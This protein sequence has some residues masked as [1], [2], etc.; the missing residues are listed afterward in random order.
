MSGRFRKYLHVNAS[1]AAAW[2][3]AGP[4]LAGICIFIL[5]PFLLAVFLSFTNLALGSPLPLEFVG[6][7]QYRVIF[8]DTGFSRALLNNLLFLTGI[9]PTQT[10][11]AL[12][13]AL[14]LNQRLKGIAIYR[15]LFFMPV[16]FPMS[17]IAVIWTLIYAPGPDGLMNTF[18]G[19][20]T[21]GAWEPRD[22]INHP[23]LALPAIMLLSVWQG[24]GF[25][26]VVLL[27]GLQ[28]I[29]ENLYEAAAIDGAGRWSRFVHVTL[30]GL[31]NPL[32][33]VI[34]ITSILSFRVFDQVRIM[35]RGGPRNA[36]TTVVFEAVRVG[37]DRGQVAMGA[38]MSVIF[39]LIV[40]LITVI[41]RRLL[42]QEG[43][44]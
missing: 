36:T 25:Q 31:R 41:Q 21:F 7:R 10:L 34:I 23:H 27:A 16:V 32:I 15:T 17:L 24:V 22:F 11:L 9:V 1:D 5:T 14:M 37:F 39:F 12:M 28:G 40:L 33:F 8:T 3:M 35:T 6:F 13:L 2:G 30:P 43:V 20:V 38:A 19:I 18:L 42:K 26:M 44:Q 4:A 29:P